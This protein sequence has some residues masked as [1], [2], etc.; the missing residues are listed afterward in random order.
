MHR[1]DPGA[2]QRDLRAGQADCAAEGGSVETALCEQAWN[3][4]Q[5]AKVVVAPRCRVWTYRS[6]CIVLGCSQR[7]LCADIERRLGGRAGLVQRD[8]G[9]GAVLTGPWLVS[10]LVVL[11]HGHP[12]VCDG[13]IDS[14]RRLGQLH[15]A[16]LNQVGVAARALP[17][18]EV[19]G[20]NE[21]SAIRVVDWACFGGFSPWEIVDAHARKLV[22]FAQK[23]QQSGVLLV[24][25][26]LI[27]AADWSLLCD[28]MG[29]P[30]D[31]LALRQ[32]TISAEEIAGNKIEPER[33]AAVLMQ[34]LKRVVSVEATLTGN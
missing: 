33:F 15:V 3:R 24:A 1:E 12:W 13:L 23:R 18:R 6:P 34:L 28:V 8:S 11:P 26:T 30:G 29:H 25:G 27:G 4:D 21:S 19:P 5:L 17:P 2:G 7:R 14:Y 32:R 20:V 22:G 10:A 31:E 16:A 9:G